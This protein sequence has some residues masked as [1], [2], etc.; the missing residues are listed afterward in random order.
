MVAEELKCS[1]DTVLRRHKKM[2]TQAFLI[3]SY[4]TRDLKIEE[5]LAYDGIENFAFSQFDPNN[6]NHAIGRDSLFVYD[7]NYSPLNRKGRMTPWQKKK[8]KKLE[9]SIGAYPKRAIFMAT[10]TLFQRLLERTPGKLL[11][12]SD[13]HYAY[14]EAIASLPERH[15]LEHTITLARKARN[16]QNRLFAVNHLDSLTRQNI[17]SFRRET[18][19]FAKHSISMVHD[20]AL[21]MVRKNFMRPLFVKKHVEDPSANIESPA[22][23]LGL[24]NKILTFQEFFQMRMTKRQ[25]GLNADWEKFVNRID[26]TSRR[27]IMAA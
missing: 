21:L 10:K 20:F 27:K 16:F 5:S 3:Q 13:N 8:K 22:M 18:I 25:A 7:F 19:A 4:K 6:I 9:D 1:L 2:S 17:A 11:L 24:V 15:R 12:H 23:K 26:P 14:R